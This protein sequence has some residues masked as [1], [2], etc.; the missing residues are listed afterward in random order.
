MLRAMPYFEYTHGMCDGRTI[1]VWLEI[2]SLR[3]KLHE[4]DTVAADLEHVITMQGVLHGGDGAQQ[5]VSTLE[6]LCK[7]RVLLRQWQPALDCLTQGDHPPPH[8]LREAS[9][10]GDGC[11]RRLECDRQRPPYFRTASHSSRAYYRTS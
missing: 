6:K 3:L 2:S 9:H 10:P 11:S 8:G 4:F 1:S 7:A 5:I